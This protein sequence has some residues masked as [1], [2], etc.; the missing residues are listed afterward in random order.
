MANKHDRPMYDIPTYV[1][2]RM[3]MAYYFV[4]PFT[5]REYLGIRES[6]LSV[7]LLFVVLSYTFSETRFGG[8][9]DSP[10]PALPV[11]DLCQIYY[12]HVSIIL[13]VIHSMVLVQILYPQR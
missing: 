10:L 1:P 4:L 6:T 12:Q 5:P 11:A 8:K 3:G 7:M 2:T 9:H 13:E